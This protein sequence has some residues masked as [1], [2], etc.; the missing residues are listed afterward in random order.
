[1]ISYCTEELGIAYNKMIRIINKNKNLYNNKTNIFIVKYIFK[2][3]LLNDSVMSA[4]N[5]IFLMHF[6]CYLKLLNLFPT[7]NNLWRFD[8]NVF[9]PQYT[10]YPRFIPKSYLL[11][12]KKNYVV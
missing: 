2:S 7:Y 6:S 4:L 10:M 5:H 11:I 3:I 8:K 12:L 1:M 9:I